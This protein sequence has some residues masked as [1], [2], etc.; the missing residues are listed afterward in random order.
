[1]TGSSLERHLRAKTGTIS[2]VSNLAG[3]LKTSRGRQLAFAI[4]IQD[5]VGSAAPWRRL[6]DEI[7]IALYEAL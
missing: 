2:G 7:C 3:Y 5:F 6:Q 4:L 1:M